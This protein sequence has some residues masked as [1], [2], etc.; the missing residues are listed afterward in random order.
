M[1]YRPPKYQENPDY[2]VT[3]VTTRTDDQTVAETC[4]LTIRWIDALAGTT[5]YRLPSG[6]SLLS[7]KKDF[8]SQLQPTVSEHCVTHAPSGG[9][10]ELETQLWLAYCQATLGPITFSLPP[11]SNDAARELARVEREVVFPSGFYG[12]GPYALV[13]DYIASLPENDRARENQKPI[14]H[15]YQAEHQK[16]VTEYLRRYQ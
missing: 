8:L 2:S 9:A 1:M 5:T 16:L 10:K 12:N 7:T 13:R 6:R 11:S 14:V 4:E 15:A 3:A